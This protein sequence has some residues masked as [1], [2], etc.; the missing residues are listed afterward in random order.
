MEGRTHSLPQ[1]PVLVPH[2]LERCGHLRKEGMFLPPL[3]L[4]GTTERCFFG[5]F[6]GFFLLLLLL[7]F[8]PQ[9]VQLEMG[10]PEPSS[11][12]TLTGFL[13]GA[14]RDAQQSHPPGSGRGTDVPGGW[15]GV[16]GNPWWSFSTG[17]AGHK[18]THTLRG[19]G[20][21]SGAGRT[22]NK[23]G[24]LKPCLVVQE[25]CQAA[26]NQLGL[27]HARSRTV[28]T[29]PWANGGCPRDRLG[30]RRAELGD[31]YLETGLKE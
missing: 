19:G 3:Q 10:L 26:S 25:G 6:C 4:G 9:Q 1:L 15:S 23:G 13:V 11:N 8:V 21:G 31:K 29:P 30:L 20:G 2:S 5:I 28:S 17:R 27:G 14:R 7:P 18:H 24:I 16:V 12:S 22:D